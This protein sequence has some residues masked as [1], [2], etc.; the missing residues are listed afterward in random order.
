M[1][2]CIA[3]ESKYGNGKKCVEYL[4]KIIN[5]KGHNSEVFSI[6]DIRPD[7]IPEADLYVFS[8]PTHIGQ[9]ARKMKKFLK[10]IV[11]Q[12]DGVKYALMATHL[13]PEASTLDKMDVFIEPKNMIKITNGLKIKVKGMKGPLE[14]GFEEKIETF[15]TVLLKND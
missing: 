4:H 14:D 12:Q 2:I 15:A 5:E 7:S 6:R 8:S 1:N 9:P 11:I 3:Y 13:D 10:K